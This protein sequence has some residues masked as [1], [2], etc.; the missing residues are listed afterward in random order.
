MSEAPLAEPERPFEAHGQ[1][2]HTRTLQLDVLCEDDRHLRIRGV[3]LDLRKCGFVPTG[4][5]L[6]TAGFIHHMGLDVVVERASRVITALQPSQQVVAF[7]ASAD[8]GGESCR[9]TPQRLQALVGVPIDAAFPRALVG[10]YGGAL[11]CTHLLTLAQL[12]G[13]TVP[14]VLELEDAAPVSRAARLPG[15]LVFKRTLILD[16]FELHDGREMD[17]AVQLNDVRTAPRAGVSTPMDRFGTQAELRVLARIEMEGVTITRILA[18]E[19]AR[20]RETLPT[21]A[22]RRLDDE[23]APLVGSPALAGLARKLLDRFS[24]RPESR[25]LL[26]TMLNFAPG[27]IQCMAAMAH[28]IVEAMSGDDEVRAAPSGLIGFGGMPN[29]C[30]IWREGGALGKLRSDHRALAERKAAD[31]SR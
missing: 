17:V 12:V 16:G 21:A 15:E 20:T 24:G 25:L 27:L 6:Q 3:I 30:Y 1:P 5:D 9:D 14:H 19:R 11:G 4:G 23:V 13:A 10:C 28:R 8:S 31:V 22:W 26:D 29:A 18:E 7:E 2:I